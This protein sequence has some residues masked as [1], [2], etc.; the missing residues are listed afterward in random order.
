ML[1]GPGE[2]TGPPPAASAATRKAVSSPVNLVKRGLQLEDVAMGLVEQV[3]PMTRR[4]HLRLHHAA[5]AGLGHTRTILELGAD[6]RKPGQVFRLLQQPHH[7]ADAK[8]L[9]RERL[10]WGRLAQAR[11][12]RLASRPLLL[13]P[14][15][16]THDCS[17]VWATQPQRGLHAWLGGQR[18]PLNA[19]T[20]NLLRDVNAGIRH[21]AAAYGS[22]T[23]RGRKVLKLHHSL[24]H[25]ARGRGNPLPRA[26]WGTAEAGRRGGVA[27]RCTQEV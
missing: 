15:A 5:E 13:T 12:G 6:V 3:H 8:V 11:R 21:C 23:A 25:Q 10:R 18:E 9:C 14:S 22:S 19:P 20:T 4:L 27:G 1:T 24:R 7:L 16:L 26:T 17:M 2:L